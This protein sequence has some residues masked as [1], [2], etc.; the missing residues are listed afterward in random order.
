M[1]KMSWALGLLLTTIGSSVLSQPPGG[2]G[3]EGPGRPMGGPGNPIV[4]ALD[5]NHDG[6]I[7]GEE[8]KNAAV[9]LAALDKDG[10]GTLTQEEFRP[11][12]GPEG[13]GPGGPE[14]RGPGGPEG[15]GP[16]GPE[17]RGPGGPEGRGPG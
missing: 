5:A 3:P 15:R 2:R 9:A 6:E 8:I 16:G 14:G 13:R 7:S 11:A 4:E 12:R 1:K 10:N 17:G